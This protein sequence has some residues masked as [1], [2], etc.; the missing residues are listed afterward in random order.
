KK[1]MDI[2]SEVDKWTNRT[3]LYSTNN[4]IFTLIKDIAKNIKFSDA[5]TRSEMIESTIDLLER[6]LARKPSNSNTINFDTMYIGVVGGPCSGKSSVCKM[7]SKATGYQVID[8][9]SSI[10]SRIE[11]VNGVIL[12]SCPES[13]SEY[14]KLKKDRFFITHLSK[15][16]N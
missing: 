4:K 15:L 13:Y 6:R 5:K 12:D 7:L 14:L 9:L 10:K 1:N 2:Y 8:P 11:P 3:L 16:D